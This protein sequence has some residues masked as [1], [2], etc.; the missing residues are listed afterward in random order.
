MDARTDLF[1][2]GAV[3]Y[4][5]VT[6]TVPFRGEGSGDIFDAILHKPPTAPVRLNP[7]VP[8]E[9][10]R[11]INK[12]LEKDRD[13]RFQH[14]SEMRADLKRLKRETESG[15][16]S[17]ESGSVS[18]SGP[19]EPQAS[20]RG[21]ASAAI[22]SSASVSSSAVLMAEAKRNKGKLIGVSVVLVVLAIVASLAAYKL[23]SRNKL[24][25]DT[26]NITIRQLTE[27]GQVINFANISADGRL[28]AYGRR[29]GER[30]L[31]VKQVATGSE[32]IVVPPQPGF[33]GY[34]ATF[35]PDGNYLY[36]THADPT[37]ANSTNV[38][39]VPALGGA[40]RQ[41]VSDVVSAAA[42]S[43]DGRQIVYR[44]TIRDKGEDQILIA[45]TDGSGEQV[46]LRHESGL[47][48]L[49]G[50]PSWSASNLIAVGAFE[51]GQNRIT[52]I[53]VI[54][55]DG[56]LVTSFPLP[57]VFRA[58]AWLPD[59]SGLFFI[60]AEKSTGLRPQ[61]WF[62][63]Y[64]DGDAFKIT[65]DLNQYDSLSV[66][67]DGKSFVSTQ[68][69]QQATIYVGDSPSIL[70]DK[71]D[72]KL[73][74]ISNEQATGYSL[75]WT[76]AG[77]LLQVDSA[78]RPYLTGGDGSNRARLLE[79]DEMGF[80]PQACSGD[81]VVVSR[82]GE[83]NTPNLWRL[84]VATG[85]LKQLT[86]LKDVETS[87]CAPDGKSVVY[88]GLV[89][90]DNVTHIFRV[91]IDGGAAVELAKGQVRE[92]VVSP[93]STLVA[94]LRN[95]GQGAS[96]KSK[97]VV[98]RLEG[99]APL[100]E[101]EMPSTRNWFALGWTP[102]GRALTYERNTT[103]NTQNVYMQPLAGGAPVQ[104]THFDSEPAL[105]SAYAW[106]RDGKKFAV[107]RARYNDTDVVLFGGFR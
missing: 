72:W 86:F 2:F 67:A 1:S 93:D 70:N 35:T 8:V 107:T 60:T 75:S 43:P 74:P 6:G 27:H 49:I 17:A 5:M 65:N 24:A 91:S 9:L 21:S 45:N 80:S 14:A 98:Q 57:T 56:K 11:I 47:K 39:A 36:Y 99:G 33:F 54:T 23:L 32:V 73:T 105:I 22:P 59:S 62:Q 31:R 87:S 66:T 15:R 46:I 96:A 94:Y 55:P 85:E 63:P 100:Q 77:K 30:S 41:I 92:P 26:R 4:E 102:D 38:Y 40:S 53:I 58:V 29:E 50:D 61:I 48:G 76:G 3:L 68:E 19:V 20:A 37:N 81:L 78:Y 44:R 95:D 97:I 18:A 69:R 79:N 25:I 16:V 106:S 101:I 82:V 64:P 103:G 12:A 52:T 42:F 83:S 7:E 89:D 71:I 88:P 28:V 104:L 13:L 34:G 51:Q 90:A 10:E 84:N